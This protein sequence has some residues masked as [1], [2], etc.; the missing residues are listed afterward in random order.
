MPRRGVLLKISGQYFPEMSVNG[1]SYN[2]AYAHAAAS[3]PLHSRVSVRGSFLYGITGGG[4]PLP[5][6]RYYL[7][8]IMS[9]FDYYGKRDVSFFGYEPFEFSGANAYLAGADIQLQVTGRWIVA[10]HFAAGAAEDDRSEVFRSRNTLTGW[11]GTAAYET[12]V[13]PVELTLAGS[14][15]SSLKI[16]IGI[17]YR[18]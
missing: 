10:G 2:R 14:E 15:R 5:H 12:P 6:H 7:G 9:W 18:F 16:W 17:G 4:S 3:I 11:A 8:G 1:T 13:G